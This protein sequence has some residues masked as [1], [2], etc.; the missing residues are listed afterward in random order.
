LGKLDL[1]GSGGIGRNLRGEKLIPV[2]ML[3]ADERASREFNRLD[4]PLEPI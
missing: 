3:P 1:P 2:K 4:P